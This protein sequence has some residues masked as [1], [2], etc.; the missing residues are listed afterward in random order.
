[1]RFSGRFICTWLYFRD[2]NFVLRTTASIFRFPSEMSVS[3]SYS[4]G[5]KKTCESLMECLRTLHRGFF[6]YLLSFCSCGL[7]MNLC[8]Y[9]AMLF[10][11]SL[12]RCS[13][14]SKIFLTF[15]AT[16]SPYPISSLAVILAW[17]C[18]NDAN[19]CYS[20]S[21]SASLSDPV[22]FKQNHFLEQSNSLENLSTRRK[23]VTADFQRR[24]ET[25]KATFLD[26]TNVEPQF[27]VQH[28]ILNPE[29]AFFCP[30]MVSH[31]T[32]LTDIQILP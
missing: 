6:R 31:R 14:N 24:N 7:Q 18:P 2:S 17:F 5:Q 1:M 30:N 22:Y 13:H 4:A 20:F 21:T 16:T 8:G 29:R 10:S 27:P 11:R 25:S 28:N 19:L 3:L 32:A 15:L 12:P 26:G 23:I 9:L